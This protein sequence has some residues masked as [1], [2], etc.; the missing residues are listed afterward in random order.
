MK[1][2]TY[3]SVTYKTYLLTTDQSQRTFG[4]FE[5]FGVAQQ[6]LLRICTREDV[7]SAR[8]VVEELP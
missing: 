4:P 3:L 7:V 8:I 6:A 1:P 5:T 2:S